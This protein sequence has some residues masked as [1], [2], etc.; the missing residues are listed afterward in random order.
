MCIRDRLQDKPGAFFHEQAKRQLKETA[1]NRKQLKKQPLKNGNQV[2]CK[3]LF[4]KKR[5]GIIAMLFTENSN[6]N[7]KNEEVD[8]D[9]K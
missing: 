4:F 7:Q 3:P 9:E 5:Y 2:A 1:N 6:K 8:T